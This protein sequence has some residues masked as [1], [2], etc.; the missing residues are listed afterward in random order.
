M[1]NSEDKYDE[2]VKEFQNTNL[3]ITTEG[4]KYL[5]G[6]IGSNRYKCVNDWV[7]QIMVLSEIAKLEP[8]AAYTSFTAGFI[9]KF[10][11]HI[12]LIDG[13]ELTLKQ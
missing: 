11:Y 7:K 8:Q 4:H 1:D 5:G 10:T 3:N 2:T 6:V 12:R 9:N 13:I